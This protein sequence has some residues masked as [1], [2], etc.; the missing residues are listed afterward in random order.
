MKIL[1]ME[2]ALQ[3]WIKCTSFHVYNLL[4]V[5]DI[6]FKLCSYVYTCITI[7]FLFCL[8]HFCKLKIKN[9]LFEII[10]TNTYI[11]YTQQTLVHMIYQPVKII[12]F[13]YLY[14]SNLYQYL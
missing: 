14:I 9:L 6:L 5:H 12:L 8:A 1:Y 13:G 2:C 3:G 11:Y 10:G 4:M 7:F